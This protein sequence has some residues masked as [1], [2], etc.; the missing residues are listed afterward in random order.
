MR[1]RVNRMLTA[2]HFHYKFAFLL[3]VGLLICVECG[4][5]T[6]NISPVPTPTRAI[7]ATPSPAQHQ[8]NTDAN[9]CAKRCTCYVPGRLGD[10]QQFK[11]VR[12]YVSA[13]QYYRCAGSMDGVGHLKS[14]SWR[15][16]RH[17]DW[18]WR[19]GSKLQQSCSNWHSRSRRGRTGCL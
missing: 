9:N 11:L 3:L 5:G 8:H 17:M 15:I 4:C 12:L 2:S 13:R 7:S 10:K 18:R 16:C 14:S 19:M 1:G 6:A